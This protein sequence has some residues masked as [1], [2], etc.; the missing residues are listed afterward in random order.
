MSLF[1]SILVFLLSLGSPLLGDAKSYHL[2]TKEQITAYA[3]K[4]MGTA[5]V[6]NKDKFPALEGITCFTLELYDE[7]MRIPHWHPNASEL[8]YVISGTVEILIWRSPGESAVYVIEEGMCWFIPQGALHCLN[9]IGSEK[10][11]LLVGFSNDSPQDMDLP[12][13]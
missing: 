6:V 5:W 9:N 4:N 8:G 2:Q 1:K 7:S 10:A 3:V 11:Q 13:A 12:V